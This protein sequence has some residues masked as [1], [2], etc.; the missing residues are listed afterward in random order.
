MFKNAA[1]LS[2]AALVCAA[3]CIASD[4]DEP[5]SVSVWA[6][7]LFGPDGK[8]AEYAI[9]DEDKYPAKFVEN[10][11]VRLARAVIPP[12]H[13]DGIPTTLRTG[14]ELRF[15]VTRTAQGGSVRVDGIAMGPLPVKQYFASYPR[16]VARSGGWQ[17][18]VTGVCTVGVDGRC[19]SIEVA[20]LPGI[21]ESVRKFMRASLEGWEFEP[22]L[23]DG[24]PVE[25]QYT[26]KMRLNTLD[27]APEYFR[28]DKFL[29]VL[30]SR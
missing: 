17:G 26:L 6:R 1:L 12:P 3:P 8:P 21:P 25:G 28:E 23:L 20:A 18:D 13:I 4:S 11:K 2:A 22:Q 9:L 29:R 27:D 24:Q 7:L 5:Y 16:D 10:V 30:R 14:V 19:R 15:T